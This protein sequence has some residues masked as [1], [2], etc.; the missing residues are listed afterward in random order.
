[1]KKTMIIGSLLVVVVYGKVEN[2]LGDEQS[3]ATFQ[4]KQEV[5]V[6]LEF[7]SY[8]GIVPPYYESWTL[9]CERI[10]T[11]KKAIAKKNTT[12]VMESEAVDDLYNLCIA[13]GSSRVLDTGIPVL[14]IIM[15][16]QNGGRKRYRMRIESNSVALG[17]FNKWRKLGE[18]EVKARLEAPLVSYFLTNKIGTYL[19]EIIDYRKAMQ[20]RKGGRSYPRELSLH[21][22][23][24]FDGEVNFLQRRWKKAFIRYKKLISEFENGRKGLAP[25]RYIYYK[26]AWCCFKM[27][28][29]NKAVDL[30]YKAR[31]SSN[32][33]MDSAVVNDKNRWKSL[34]GNRWK[35]LLGFGR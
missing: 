1:M 33:L 28:K 24:Y 30:I 23:Q 32:R 26:A 15:E 5:K 9:G 16:L 27:R 22:I 12:T 14:N 34:L 3:C 4:G 19:K 18:G 20:E 21:F 7:P 2:S 35:R 17:L 25:I 29:F 6:E 31:G 10:L 11:F 8:R 13:L